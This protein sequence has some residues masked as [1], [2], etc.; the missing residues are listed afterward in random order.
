MRGSSD[1]E[2]K[3]HNFGNI[4]KYD[5]V[6]NVTQTQNRLQKTLFISPNTVENVFESYKDDVQ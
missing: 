4:A 5:T 1:R 3:R 2:V 6:E